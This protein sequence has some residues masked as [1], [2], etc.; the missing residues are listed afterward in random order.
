M[1]LFEMHCNI[2]VLFEA[3][4][5]CAYIYNVSQMLNELLRVQFYYCKFLIG[6]GIFTRDKC[7]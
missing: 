5:N 7:R 4:K 2:A 1:L 6:N 3:G